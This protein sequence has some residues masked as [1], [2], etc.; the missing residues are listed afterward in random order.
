M[1]DLTQAPVTRTI[2][3]MAIPVAASMIFQTL[4]VLID[5]YFVAALGEDSVA[6]VGTAGTLMFM[7]MAFTQVLGVSAVALIAQAV[8]RKD[9]DTA[10]LVFNQSL[11]LSVCCSLLTLLFGYLFGALFMNGIAADAGAYA[12]GLTFLHWLLPGMALQFPIIAMAS[13]LRA[14]GIVQPAMIIQVVTVLLNIALAPVLIAGWGPGPALG[15]MGAGLATTLASGV[16]LLLL[17]GYFLKLEKYVAFDPTRWQP[18]FKLWGRML[19]IGLPA[20]GEMLLLFVYFSAVY[21]LI[22]DFGTA[23]QAGFSIGGRVMQSIFMPTMAIAFAVGPIIGQNF[24][25][26]CFARVRETYYKGIL[27]SSIVMLSV[28]LFIHWRP[29]VLVGLFTDQV[30]VIQVASVFLQ[31]V[32]LNF[33]TQGI[34]FTSSGVFQGL[35]NTRPALLSSLLRIGFFIPLAILVSQRPD[36]RIEHLW[37]LSV[38]S[39]VLQACFSV[40]LVLREFRLKLADQPPATVHN[41]AEAG[42][43][44]IVPAPQEIS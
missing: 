26:G 19:D 32:S 36:Y 17:T 15:V 1:R 5:L 42:N 9:R 25:A 38:A 2:L 13:S 29:G 33:L 4:Y 6:G 41:L 39:V 43:E 12:E 20:G 21:F 23:A 7:I 11:V 31:I 14:T 37:Y 24:G 27:L 44:A 8:G 10:N 28:T 16:G 30:E 18:Q 3:T 34:V 35:G 40:W 22:Q